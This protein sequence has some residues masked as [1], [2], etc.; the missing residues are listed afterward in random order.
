[1]EKDDFT[2]SQQIG[3]QTDAVKEKKFSSN[4]K[5]ENFLIRQSRFCWM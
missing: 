2:L 5:P 1:M 4:Q 3:K